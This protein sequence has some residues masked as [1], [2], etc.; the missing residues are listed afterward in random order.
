MTSED[1]HNLGTAHVL[2]RVKTGELKRAQAQQAT[3]PQAQ[4]VP[5]A[6]RLL[7]LHGAAAYLGLSE[8]TTRDLEYAGVLA[9]VRVPLPGNGQLRKLLFDKQDLD[10]LVEV[11]KDSGPCHEP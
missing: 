2:R 8:W 7:D 4:V 10:R 3:A 1:G 5:I 6:P 9:R 11:W